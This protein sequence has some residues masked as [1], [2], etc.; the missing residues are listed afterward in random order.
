M[1]RRMNRLESSIFTQKI[2][3]DREIETIELSLVEA[4]QRS[5]GGY[6]IC[7]KGYGESPTLEKSWCVMS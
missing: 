2:P 4:L 3:P 7:W 1:H 6:E 5:K